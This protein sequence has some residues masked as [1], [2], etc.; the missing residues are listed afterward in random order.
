MVGSATFT[1]V[2]SMMF[3]NIAATKTTLTAIFWFTAPFLPEV[4]GR[5]GPESS[6]G[7]T[8]M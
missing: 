3:M 6:Y 1:I 5:T 8:L 2:V 7:A 4:G